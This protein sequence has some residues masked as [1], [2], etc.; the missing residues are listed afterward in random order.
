MSLVI[1]IRSFI[2]GLLI[3]MVFPAQAFNWHDWFTTPDQQAMQMLNQGQ[4]E[5]AAQTF[6]RDDWRATSAYRAGD[7]SVAAKLYPS[8]KNESASYNE[9]NALAHMGQYESAIKAYDRAIAM[10]PHDEDAIYN[11][12]IIDELLKKQ[13]EKQQDQQ[14]QQNQQN[15]Q[16]QQQKPDQNQQNKQEQAQQNQS[17][18]QQQQNQQT[19]NQQN[20]QD[21]PQQNQQTNNQPEQ[22]NQPQPKTQNQDQQKQNEPSQQEATNTNQAS[23]NSAKEDQQAKEQLMQIIP[24]DPGGLL[25]E[26]F[27]RD[28]MRRQ[29]GYE[30]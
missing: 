7:Y 5:Q 25:K 4:Y 28:Y 9:G 13:K 29:Q 1:Y 17:E 23:S 24:D 20:K 27:H 14:Q 21:Q 6:Q 8:L 26:K 12:K 11:R 30:P 18:Q 10:N 16:N 22:Q 3:C 2:L 19:N 15:Q